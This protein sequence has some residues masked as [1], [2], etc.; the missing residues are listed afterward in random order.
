VKFVLRS[1]IYVGY[2]LL[3][4][5][6]GVATTFLGMTIG[7]ALIGTHIA[8]KQHLPHHWARSWMNALVI[9]P[10][11]ITRVLFQL[12]WTPVGALIFLLNIIMLVLTAYDTSF[13]GVSDNGNKHAVYCMYMFSFLHPISRTIELEDN[14]IPRMLRDLATD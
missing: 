2:S 9:K 3:L 8:F 7:M 12:V 1:I 6:E 10:A 14:F 5:V 11:I 13:C 4:T